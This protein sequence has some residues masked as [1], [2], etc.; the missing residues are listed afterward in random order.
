[1]FPTP[2]HLK[3]NLLRRP[4]NAESHSGLRPAVIYACELPVK[5]AVTKTFHI[6]IFFIK[7]LMSLMK[8]YPKQ[9]RVVSV[10]YFCFCRTHAAILTAAVH[11]FNVR[12]LLFTDSAYVHNN[13]CNLIVAYGADCS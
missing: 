10:F 4:K 6:C 8:K 5:Q 11:V 13:I 1:M 9:L 3:R 7:L 2:A 12:Y